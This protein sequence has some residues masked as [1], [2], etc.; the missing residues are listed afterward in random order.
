MLEVN[1]TIRII[2]ESKE[3]MKE[4]AIIIE[5]GN[6]IKEEPLFNTQG[7]NI[8]SHKYLFEVQQSAI[9]EGVYII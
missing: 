3:K 6:F 2:G 8:I 7:K 5:P 1:D 4:K 9:K